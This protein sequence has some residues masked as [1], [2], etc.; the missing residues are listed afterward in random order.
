MYEHAL[1]LSPILCKKADNEPLIWNYPLLELVPNLSV[2]ILFTPA[3]Y[4]QLVPEQNEFKVESS[5]NQISDNFP[6]ASP[7]A[8]N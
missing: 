5:Q 3:C 7:Q 6:S 8:G 1:P 4:N 2:Y